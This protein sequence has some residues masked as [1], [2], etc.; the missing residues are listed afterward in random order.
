[1]KI[2]DTVKYR[3]DGQHMW[4]EVL[5]IED[6]NIEMKLLNEPYKGEMRWPDGSVSALQSQHSHGDVINVRASEFEQYQAQRAA[7]SN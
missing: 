4:F 2:G 6:D 7:L 5:S 3:L 1:M